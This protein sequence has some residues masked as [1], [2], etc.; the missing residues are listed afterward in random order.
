MALVQQQGSS[1]LPN[2]TNIN[3]LAQQQMDRCSFPWSITYAC[4]QLLQ[5][6]S[7]YI[8][9]AHC[10]IC[11]PSLHISNM[12]GFVYR[13]ISLYTESFCTVLMRLGYESRS[14]VIRSFCGDNVWGGWECVCQHFYRVRNIV[15]TSD[16]GD[17][18]LIPYCDGG[19]ILLV[20]MQ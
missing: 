2:A 13:C 18:F 10:L 17:R 19:I 11:A 5:S 6:F 9:E 3:E 1:W 14:R 4:W 16:F 7:W 12:P 20:S 8:S 15:I